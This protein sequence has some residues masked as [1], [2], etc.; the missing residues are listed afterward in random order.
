M[1]FPPEYKKVY[2]YGGKID[3]FQKR[4]CLSPY[5]DAQGLQPGSLEFDKRAI[6]VMHEFLLKHLAYSMCQK[7][8]RDLVCS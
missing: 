8:E 5:A 6:A 1:K 2:R 3:H 7:E 4:S